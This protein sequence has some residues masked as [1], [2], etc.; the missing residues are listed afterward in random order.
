MKCA[1]LLVLGVI[2]VCA[3]Q[4]PLLPDLFVPPTPA[5][6]PGRMVTERITN[7]V[8]RRHVEFCDPHDGK[9]QRV[10]LSSRVIQLS[11]AP[12]NTT[13]SLILSL[14]VL[15][16]ETNVMPYWTATASGLAL[17]SNYR[18]MQS[19][20]GGSNWMA[21]N[22][23]Y[24]QSTNHDF[25]LPVGPYA[26][27]NTAGVFRLELEPVIAPTNASPMTFPFRRP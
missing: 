1:A 5:L 14:P 22:H 17:G 20:D 24:A 8:E 15:V 21:A 18:L 25:K 23:F 9:V 10:L 26:P 16:N 3:A 13:N 11:D 6:N 7:I 12:T 19:L 4:P 2:A 27:F